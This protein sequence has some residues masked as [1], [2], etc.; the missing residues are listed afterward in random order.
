MFTLLILG[1]LASAAAGVIL[2]LVTEVG[3]LGPSPAWAAPLAGGGLAAAAL[4]WILQRLARRLQKLF[5]R[6]CIQC[7][8]EAVK[9]SIYCSPHLRE[10]A[11]LQR[12]RA[13]LDRL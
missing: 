12:E 2:L 6:R 5:R 10:V 13:E 11:V 7:G 9:G 4:G 3:G 1:G 8:R